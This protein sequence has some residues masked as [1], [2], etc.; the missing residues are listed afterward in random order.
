MAWDVL[1]DNETKFLLWGAGAGSGKSYLGCSWE[2]M[3]CYQYPGSK[4]FVGRKELKRLMG[5][6]FITFMKLFKDLKIPESDWKLNG[7]YNYIE[8]RNGSRIDLLDLA[9][10]PQDPL[11]ERF[12][13]LEYT[14]GWI[15]EAGEVEFLAFDTLKSRIGRHLNDSFGL[16]PAKMLLTCNP[17]QNWL[18]RV[19]Y[20][21]FRA[22]TLPPD[23]AFIQAL[24]EDNP[25]LDSTYASNLESMTD[26][27]MKARLLRG[28]WEYVEGDLSLIKYDSLLDM[29]TNAPVFSPDLYLTADVARYGGDRIVYGIWRG[30]D[31]TEIIWK[32]RQGI[33]QTITDIRTILFEKRIPYSH[34]V[35]DED[36]VG[37]GVIDALKGV[38]GFVG[39]SAPLRKKHPV[40][41]VY[42]EQKDNYQNLRSQC[43]FMIA[44][45]LNDHKISASAKITEDTREWIIE[46][47]QQIKRKNPD[48]DTK[49][50]V[51]PKEDIKDALGRSPDFADM[52]MMRMYFELEIPQ[53]AF[54]TPKD[55]GGVKPYF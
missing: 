44:D 4:W 45:Y 43:L 7:Q 26:Y 19:F 41:G 21:P 48:A 5:S 55:V 22:G 31:L 25:H 53:K 49:L 29:F 52:I 28:V 11:F 36:G 10:K 14:G 32:Q 51:I 42:E 40:T 54:T 39:N 37:G 15:E 34:V 1:S 38:K 18:Y 2:T 8:F 9:S 16:T 20:K 24:H 30:L 33:D 50:A 47:L 23:Y 3:M 6:T 46:E 27:V 13:S 12:G 35:I 17:T